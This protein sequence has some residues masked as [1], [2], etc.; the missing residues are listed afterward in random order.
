MKAGSRTNPESI[1]GKWFVRPDFAAAKL[2]N[3]SFIPGIAC[4]KEAAQ[5]FDRKDFP[6][7]QKGDGGPERI[8]G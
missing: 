2:L 8:F 1:A 7:L 4:Q 3:R 6:F 5:P